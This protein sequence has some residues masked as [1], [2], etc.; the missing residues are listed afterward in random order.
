VPRATQVDPSRSGVAKPG[1]RTDSQPTVLVSE[2]AVARDQRPVLREPHHC[3]AGA[4]VRNRSNMRSPVGRAARLGIRFGLGMLDRPAVQPAPKLED[5]AHRRVLRICTWRYTK[6]NS[7]HPATATA[8][9]TYH[10][11]AAT[12]T[13]KPPSAM[14][15]SAGK[16]T[17]G[18]TQSFASTA[19]FR[20]CGAF[21]Q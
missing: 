14:T 21:S 19:L 20:C 9:P 10:L 7:A 17:A 11:P 8:V 2:Q 5:E 4:P 1:V 3:L 12:P 18:G 6:T 15:A 13:P 16:T